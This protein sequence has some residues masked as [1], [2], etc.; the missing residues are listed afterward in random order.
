T[1]VTA[2]THGALVDISAAGLLTG[3][4][5]EGTNNLIVAGATG[6]EGA[7]G[8]KL[9][10]TTIATPADVNSLQRGSG[11]VFA[12]TDSAINAPGVSLLATSGAYDTALRVSTNAVAVDAA[13]NR[14]INTL[15]AEAAVLNSS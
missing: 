11:T 4:R 10:G 9:D 12:G 6:N 2:Q 7:N 15:E 14:V 13:Q 5:L 3:S 8:L 1:D